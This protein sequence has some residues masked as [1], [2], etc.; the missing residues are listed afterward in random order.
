[1][2]GAAVV[3]LVVQPGLAARLSSRDVLDAY[4]ASRA[5]GEPLGIVGDVGPGA[6]FYAGDDVVHLA[7]RGELTAFLRRPGRVYALTLRARAGSGGELCPLHKAADAKGPSVVVIDDSNDRL[8]LLSNR[9]GPGERDRN[10]LARSVVDALPADLGHPL[11]VELEGSLRLRGVRMP[12][13]V[14]RG[15]RFEVTLIFEVLRPISRNWKVF[16]HF[17]GPG[18]RFNGDHEPID[19]VCGLSFLRPGDVVL[20]TFTV[21]AGGMLA[22][23]PKG[24]YPVYAGLFVGSSPNFTNGKVT[25][26]ATDPDGRIAIGSLR[27]R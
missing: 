17:D 10:P 5:P 3:S 20:D 6:R 22:G 27:L 2:L 13:A 14:D 11:D 21:R 4:R 16:V 1:V 26:G 8:M 7:G 25:R 15:A 23:T 24:D 19:G 12:A 18:A 9:L